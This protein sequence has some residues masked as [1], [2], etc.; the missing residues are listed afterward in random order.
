MTI[1]VDIEGPG[2]NGETI[3]GDGSLQIMPRNIISGNMMLRGS[4]ELVF[5]SPT[6]IDE[7]PHRGQ[8]HR[9][10]QARSVNAMSPNGD[11]VRSWWARNNTIDN[12]IGGTAP[13]AGNVISDNNGSG[14]SLSNGAMNNLILGNFIGTN[15][16][17][18]R[19]PNS[20]DGVDLLG[21]GN[22]TIGVTARE[23]VFSALVSSTSGAVN[24]DPGQLRIGTDKFRPS[25]A[26]RNNGDGVDLVGAEQ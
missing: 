9:H 13:D 22:N 17:G 15:A 26:L 14:I 18:T 10:G 11:G 23:S 6:A 24:F 3:G 20:G 1:R 5:G 4:V 8:F 12:T 25:K 7:K 2:Q 19:L 21:T 16:S